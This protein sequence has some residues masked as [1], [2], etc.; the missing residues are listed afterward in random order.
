MTKVGIEEA[1]RAIFQENKKV[2]VKH[3]TNDIDVDEIWQCGKNIAMLSD[4]KVSVIY[5]GEFYIL[6]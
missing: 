6:E 2:L 1:L 3:H 4:I 5:H